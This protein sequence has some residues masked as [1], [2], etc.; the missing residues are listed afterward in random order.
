MWA[1]L[2]KYMDYRIQLFSCVPNNLIIKGRVNTREHRC[3]TAPQVKILLQRRPYVTNLPGVLSA[4]V[5]VFCLAGV[6]PWADMPLLQ[7]PVWDTDRPAFCPVFSASSAS[8]EAAPFH[9]APPSPWLSKSSSLFFRSSGLS[10]VSSA[11]ERFSASV[12]SYKEKFPMGE[13]TYELW[14]GNWDAFSDKW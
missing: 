14:L 12:F 8:P 10:Q 5:P 6:P 1:D 3:K 7:E 2:T 13:K 11:V 9:L 4:L